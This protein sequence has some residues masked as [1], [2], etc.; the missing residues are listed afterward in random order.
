MT[1]PA[2]YLNRELSWLQFNTRVL[3]EAV[4]PRHPLLERLM[5]LSISGSN[6]DEF[7]MVRVSGL[8]ELIKENIK[9]PSIDGKSPL[10]QLEDINAV[11]GEL[12]ASQQSIWNGLRCELATSGIEL[13]EAAD[14]LPSE[15]EQLRATFMRAVFPVLT[16]LAVD[17][18][19]PFPFIPNLGFTVAF[20][21]RAA[22]GKEMTALVPV[23]LQAPRFLPVRK[24]PGISRCVALETAIGMFADALFP[25]FEVLGSGAFRI[26]RD[27]DVEIEEEAE[28]L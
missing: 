23:P 16:P 25:G 21:L 17:M 26:I 15:A 13:L 18:A 27:S 1:A 4:N 5:F 28:D 2:R 19:H 6:L 7:Y 14:V 9:T 3:K 22:S 10:R 12:M 24:A 20:K 8:L 11:A